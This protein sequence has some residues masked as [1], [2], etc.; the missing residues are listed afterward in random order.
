ML[1]LKVMQIKKNLNGTDN[2]WLT[3][4]AIDEMLQK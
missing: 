2:I 4:Q 1:Y 3:F